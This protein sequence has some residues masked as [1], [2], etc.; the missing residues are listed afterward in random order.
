MKTFEQ[1]N[2]QSIPEQIYEVLLMVNEVRRELK[3]F[4]AE[5]IM[6][7]SPPDENVLKALEKLS[8]KEGL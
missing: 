5:I 4:N 6:E 1:F 8:T 3:K 2:E 7:V